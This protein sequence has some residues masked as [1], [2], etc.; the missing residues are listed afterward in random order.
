MWILGIHT[1][2]LLQRTPFGGLDNRPLCSSTPFRIL[3]NQKIIIQF[4]VI[5]YFPI[6]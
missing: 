5:A 6:T 2:H 3:N 4:N 1:M